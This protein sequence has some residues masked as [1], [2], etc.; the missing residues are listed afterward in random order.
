MNPTPR[1]YFHR[2]PVSTLSILHSRFARVFHMPTAKYDHE[3]SLSGARGLSPPVS[4]DNSK[5]FTE[6]LQRIPRERER[7]TIVL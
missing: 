3:R 2:R 5:M 4:P 1:P 6:E 7:V